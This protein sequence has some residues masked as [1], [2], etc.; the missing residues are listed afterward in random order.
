MRK[1]ILI[2][3]VLMG[4]LTSCKP[5]ESDAGLNAGSADLSRYVAIGGSV[6]A[7]FLDDALSYEGQ[8]NSLAAIL[9][10]QFKKVGGA[11]ITHPWLPSAALGINLEGKT[12]LKLGYK[13]DCEGVTSL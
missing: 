11:G 8:A 9:G 13:T 12:A 6:T 10:E 5:K 7:G 1:F 3:L 4:A 2:G